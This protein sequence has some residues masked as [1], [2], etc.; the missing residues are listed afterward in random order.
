MRNIVQE[1]AAKRQRIDTL[2]SGKHSRRIDL[3]FK[4]IQ[5]LEDAEEA[6]AASDGP[7]EAV[8]SEFKRYLPIATVSC[9]ESYMRLAIQDLVDAGSPYSE[10]GCKLLDGRVQTEYLAHLQGRRLTVGELVAHSTKLSTLPDIDRALSTL[11]NLDFLSYLEAVDLEGEPFN[12][13]AEFSAELLRWNNNFYS[14][15]SSVFQA[16]H[17]YCHEFGVDEALDP[18]MMLFVGVML[19]S[20]FAV[21]D[22]V[23][24]MAI[25][26][27]DALAR[28]APA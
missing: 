28:R 20:F 27:P 14:A 5:R 1:I 10:R 21:C 6:L 4:R 22:I 17:I 19:P 8:R 15:L 18:M 9:I 2:Q 26:H 25:A 23:I 12:I 3:A 7:D 13:G 24:S 11:L 16:R